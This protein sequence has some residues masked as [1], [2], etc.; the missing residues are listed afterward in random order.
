M[1]AG[2]HN[3]S[4]VTISFNGQTMTSYGTQ[5]DGFERDTKMVE[6]TPFG[7]T[8]ATYVGS[9]VKRVK[10]VKITGFYDDTA[11]TGPDAV[12]NTLS[13][14]G[15]LIVGYGNSKQSSVSAGVMTYTRKPK[16]D[17][18]TGYE[19]TLQPSGAVTET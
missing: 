9:G 15:T 14:F 18:L 2:K 6:T 8:D 13:T 4:E 7:A 5:I 11:T 16:V 19:V 17:D 3:S 12:F 1:A 10:P